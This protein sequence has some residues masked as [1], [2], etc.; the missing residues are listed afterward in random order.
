M[1]GQPVLELSGEVTPVRR[2]VGDLVRN[3]DLLPMMA[4][5]D[6]KARYRSAA[7]GIA[8]S[9]FLPLIQ[10]GVLAVVFSFVVKI[11]TEQPYVVFILSGTTAWSFFNGSLASG[12]TSIVDQS[13]IASKLYFPRLILPAVP[14]TAN[15][16]SFAISTAVALVVTLAYGLIPGPHLLLLPV[17]MLVLALLAYFAAASLAVLHVYSRDVRYIVQAGIPILFYATP[18]IYPP[19][20]VGDYRWLLDLNPATGA[21]L[22]FRWTLFGE[23]EGLGRSL[24]ATF[25]WLVVLG[26]VTLRVYRRHERTAVDRL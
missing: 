20:L 10:A 7:L 8:W 19:S 15:A 6:Y 14:A 3:L 4:M 26:A 16:F 21:V 9:V 17:A 2:L 18:V 25:A 22:F 24:L 1:S 11:E 23:V 13:G 5:Q 12:S